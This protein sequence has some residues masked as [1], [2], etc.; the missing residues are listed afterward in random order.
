MISLIVAIDNNNVIGKDNNIPWRLPADQAY[1]KKVT[2][3]HIVIMG[4]KTYESMGKPLPGRTNWIITSDIDYR[5]EGCRIF[6]TVDEVISKI[7]GEEV[8]IIGGEKIYKEF[9]HLADKL[10]ITRIKAAFKG[11]TFFPEIIERQWR[12]ISTITGERN[13][14]NPYE[15]LYM[16]Y[17]RLF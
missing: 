4:R 10:Y 17:E 12:L 14:K 8:F 1:F 6:T 11:D 3:G 2:M 13:E 7:N 5:A 9:F 16:I 15:Y